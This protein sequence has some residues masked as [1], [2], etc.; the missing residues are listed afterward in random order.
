[1]KEHLNFSKVFIIIAFLFVCSYS[2]FGK[3]G[4]CVIMDPK[5]TAVDP[6]HMNNK[7]AKEHHTWAG[8]TYRYNEIIP[9]ILMI[10]MKHYSIYTTKKLH[11]IH[12]S[13]CFLDKYVFCSVN[14]SHKDQKLPRDQ[15][16]LRSE[17]ITLFM[18]LKRWGQRW[19]LLLL[20]IKSCLFLQK[21]LS[22][23]PSICKALYNISKIE[24]L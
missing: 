7:D 12:M 5:L 10:P 22:L 17:I 18:L 23:H 13:L 4:P 14:R 6:V 15:N 2:W 16:I 21:T 1:M 20:K 24:L 3:E 9:V 8:C 11:Y 19:P